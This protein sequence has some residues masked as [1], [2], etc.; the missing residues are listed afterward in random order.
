L[1]ITEEKKRTQLNVSEKRD[2]VKSIKIKTNPIVIRS[3]NL[4]NMPRVTPDNVHHFSE[5]E[6]F[7]WHVYVS[8]P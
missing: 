8:T 1:A 2:I 4:Q 3:N 5:L 6:I 7:I